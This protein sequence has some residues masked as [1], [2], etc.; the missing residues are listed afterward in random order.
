MREERNKIVGDQTINE[1]YTLW[2]M[3]VGNVTVVE[4]GKLYL[5]GSIFGSLTIA[6]GGRSHIFGTVR[7]DVTVDDKAKLVHS[8]TI[9]GDLINRGGRVHVDLVSKTE[10]KVKTKEGNT[11]FEKQM[12]FEE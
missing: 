3:I 2:G 8:G 12:K 6:P 7:G 11:T 9:G 10:G 1:L 5:R 4:G